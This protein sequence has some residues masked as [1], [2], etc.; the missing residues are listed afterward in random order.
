MSTEGW[1][2]G[3]FLEAQEDRLRA[4][5]AKTRAAR[6]AFMIGFVEWMD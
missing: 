5:T 2:G 4:A 1:G 3:G 6:V